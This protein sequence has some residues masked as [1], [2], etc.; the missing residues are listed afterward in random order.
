MK[1][2]LLQLEL[3]LDASYQKSSRTLE[4]E[5][6]TYWTSFCF[7]DNKQKHA[8]QAISDIEDVSRITT[9]I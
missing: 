2:Y 6:V 8:K 3:D 1:G 7:I 9:E 4:M 5:A